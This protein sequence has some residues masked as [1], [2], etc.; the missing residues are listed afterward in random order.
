VPRDGCGAS[1]QLHD[2]LTRSE[3]AAFVS[4]T[5]HEASGEC[6]TP[7][8]GKIDY[9]RVGLSFRN[10]GFAQDDQHPVVCVNWDDAK[11]FGAW[12]S[13]KTGKTYRL[14]SEAE[15][16]YVTRAGSTTRYSFG[17]DE[18]SI[19]GYGDIAD[20]TAKKTIRGA[21]SW[22]L[23]DCEDGH[24]YTAPV[25]TFAPNAFGI[26]DVHGNVTEDCAHEVYQGAPTDGSAWTSGECSFRVLRGGDWGG[27]PQHARSASRYSPRPVHM[28]RFPAGQDARSLIPGRTHT[29]D[30]MAAFTL[31]ANK[32]DEN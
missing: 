15:R 30:T 5:K 2:G 3:F 10:P 12:L 32:T 21:E 25:S 18:K 11:V 8:N 14:L 17:D 13:K 31:V 26:R 1:G 4:E 27:Y 24:A 23:A 9:E 22:T 29:S 20:L 19:C 6:L 28:A 7:G 16:E